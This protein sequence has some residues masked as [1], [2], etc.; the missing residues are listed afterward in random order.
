LREQS[1]ETHL[2][3]YSSAARIIA[4]LRVDPACYI[5]DLARRLGAVPADYFGT[6]RFFRYTAVLG[7]GREVFLCEL[8]SG[9]LK[10]LR[11]LKSY[12]GSREVYCLISEQQAALLKSEIPADKKGVKFVIF[13]TE[14]S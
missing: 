12:T 9:D 4:S 11:E 10:T 14:V 3:P 5:C 1:Y 2:L 6:D 8:V 7:L 13:E